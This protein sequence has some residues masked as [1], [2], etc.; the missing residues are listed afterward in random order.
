MD[1]V[2]PTDQQL[3]TLRL[4]LEQAKSEFKRLAGEYAK[5]HEKYK[6]AQKALEVAIQ[7]RRVL[8]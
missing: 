4:D 8:N 7:K 2:R 6:E 1:T 5:A 3:N